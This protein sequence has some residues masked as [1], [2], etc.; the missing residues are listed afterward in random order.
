[1]AMSNDNLSTKIQSITLVILMCSKY[2]KHIF[3]F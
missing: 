1:M 3:H 2:I